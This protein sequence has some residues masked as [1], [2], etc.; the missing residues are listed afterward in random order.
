MPHHRACMH[1]QQHGQVASARRPWPREEEFPRRSNVWRATLIP[2]PLFGCSPALHT[3][4]LP[5]MGMSMPTP[6]G[7]VAVVQAATN[8]IETSFVPSKMA[9]WAKA[10]WVKTSGTKGRCEHAHHSLWMGASGSAT[11]IVFLSC[12]RASYAL[13][14]A[15]SPE[16]CSLAA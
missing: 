5:P 11:L 8:A 1:R 4:L 6:N 16:D 13:M 3:I 15:L 2:T 10:T 12:D 9:S 7:D 14:R